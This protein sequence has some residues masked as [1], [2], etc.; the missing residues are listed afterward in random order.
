MTTYETWSLFFYAAQSVVL[1]S[2]LIVYQGQL[3][4]MRSQLG[5]MKDQVDASRQAAKGQNFL[6][7]AKFLQSEDVRDARRV[8]LQELKGRDYSSWTDD[9]KSAAGKVCSSYVVAALVLQS[10]LVD[11]QPFIQTWG[12][13]I[14]LCHQILEPFVKD[15][16]QPTM[17]GPTYW[18]A[19]DQL[20]GMVEDGSRGV[21]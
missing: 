11:D 21:A 10:G 17:S 3:K 15:L 19:F 9:E 4:A 6:A 5:A 20:N 2:V 18:A 16:Q 13:S 8:V 12:P 1:V 7:L 14:R